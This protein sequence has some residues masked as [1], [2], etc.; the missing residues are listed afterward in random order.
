M[1]LNSD[2]KELLSILNE[3]QVEYLVVG[4]YAIIFAETKSSKK[5]NRITKEEIR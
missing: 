5:T 2:F 1:A 4:G 3:A